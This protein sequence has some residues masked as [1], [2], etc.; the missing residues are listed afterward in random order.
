VL[1]ERYIEPGPE[2]RAFDQEERLTKVRTG[3]PITHTIHDKGLATEI[4]PSY[5]DYSGKSILGGKRVQMQRLRKWQKRIKIGNARERNLSFALN[6][7]N[8]MV[9]T[10]GLPKSVG[11]SAAAIY[12]KAVS[13]NLI[14]GRSIEGVVAAACMQ[15]ANSLEF[16]DL[17]MRYRSI[18]RLAGKRS[19]EPTNL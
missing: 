1:E 7:L 14:R 16:L 10:L 9:S 13:K 12:R 3:A 11:E 15:H 19:G 18:L 5:R 17:S 6:E 2:W 4:G 8:R